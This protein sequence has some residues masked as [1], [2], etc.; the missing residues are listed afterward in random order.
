MKTLGK[1][2]V[3][4]TLMA[5]LAGGARATTMSV[6]LNDAIVGGT[7]VED[8]VGTNDFITNAG[9]SPTLSSD[10]PFTYTGNRSL[11]YNGAG[12]RMWINNTV[13]TTLELRSTLTIETWIK[14]G[15][16][17]SDGGPTFRLILG[18]HD[19]YGLIA[20]EQG[21][22][23]DPLFAFSYLQGGSRRVEHFSDTASA[24]LD[25]GNWHH[26]AATFDAAADEVVLYLDGV[27]DGA[28]RAAQSAGDLNYGDT[29]FRTG[30]DPF[31]RWYKGLI[32]EARVSDSVLSASE[33]GYYGTLIPEPAMVGLLGIGSLLALVRRRRG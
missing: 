7:T 20:E 15:D 6:W 33:L 2:A 17:G 22:G 18:Y 11:S 24:T 23:T 28:V 29:L 31:G 19:T 27:Q 5:M 32:D 9:N 3:L 16:N 10:T 12:Q 14:G 26:I 30:S 21:S 4:V 8:H 25:D 1:V 13:G